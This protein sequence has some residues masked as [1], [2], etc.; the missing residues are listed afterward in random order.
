[1]TTYL[2][3]AEGIR[4]DARRVH[5]ELARHGYPIGTDEH[6]EQF[7][8]LEAEGRRGE[9]GRWDAQDVLGFLGY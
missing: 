4:I 8:A 6:A 5:Q 7:E 9:D 3:S 2:D 1:M